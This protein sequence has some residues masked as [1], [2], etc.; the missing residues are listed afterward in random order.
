MTVE[1]KAKVT[2]PK[3]LSKSVLQLKMLIPPPSFDVHIQ[4]G[5]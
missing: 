4:V 5:Y 2:Y 3:N 1:S